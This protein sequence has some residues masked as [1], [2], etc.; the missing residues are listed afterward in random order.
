MRLKFEISPDLVR[1]FESMLATQSG[2]N[3]WGVEIKDLDNQ[4]QFSFRMIGSG[5]TVELDKD[6]HS[7]AWYKLHCSTREYC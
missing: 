3:V 2:E 7:G 5:W 6:C 1:K 4:Y